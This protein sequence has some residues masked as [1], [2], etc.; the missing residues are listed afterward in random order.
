MKYS[1]VYLIFIFLFYFPIQAFGLEFLGRVK[2]YGIGYNSGAST[3]D[4]DL[5]KYDSSLTAGTSDNSS[6]NSVSFYMNNYKFFAGFRKDLIGNL[7]IE[8]RGVLE[9]Y[10]FHS[11]SIINGKC[12]IG[13]GFE[14]I[15]GA[16]DMLNLQL[17]YTFC[18][19]QFGIS[20]VYILD[21]E[22][23]QQNPYSNTMNKFQYGL[24]LGFESDT[25]Y[26]KSVIGGRLYLTQNN[27]ELYLRKFGNRQ[28]I[29]FATIGLELYLVN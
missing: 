26:S 22:T 20:E 6:S 9:H 5:L 17:G 1:K 24:G 25:K 28:K 11:E 3:K 27:I 13:P 19:S 15:L 10:N 29:E 21:T 14:F 16:G 23:P 18:D 8:T 7:E 12:I 4:V 2:T